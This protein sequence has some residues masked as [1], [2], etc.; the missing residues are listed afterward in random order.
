MLPNTRLNTVQK[1]QFVDY[2]L[3]HSCLLI[4]C[5]IIY[6]HFIVIELKYEIK[7]FNVANIVDICDFVLCTWSLF[8]FTRLTRVWKFLFSLFI[9]CWLS[10][11]YLVFRKLKFLL[12]C[13]LYLDNYLYISMIF[14]F[15]LL[16]NILFDN[17]YFRDRLQA[18]VQAFL[19]VNRN[20]NITSRTS[21]Y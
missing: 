11:F 4:L 3:Y 12:V 21:C 19:T 7:M 8:R 15:V 16:P 13:L 17:C 18:M 6:L 14:S 5:W 20:C 10:D 2:L 1:L 9:L